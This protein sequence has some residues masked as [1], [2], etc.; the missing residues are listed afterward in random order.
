MDNPIVVSTGHMDSPWIAAH[1]AILNEAALDVRLDVDFRAF[2]A[3]GTC[4]EKLVWH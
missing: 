1:L 4:D 3:K 2:A